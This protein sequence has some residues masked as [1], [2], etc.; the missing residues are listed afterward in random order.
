MSDYSAYGDIKLGDKT[1]SARVEKTLEQLSSNPTTS[2]SS[3]CN[4]PHQAKAVYR[5]LSNDKFTADAVLEVSQK[6]TMR[7]IAESGELV[8]LMPQDTTSLNY[9]GL[10][11]TEGLGTICDNKNALGILLHSSIAVSENGQ[12]FG[13]LSAKAWVRPPEEFGKK[14][15][16]KQLPIEE[17][18][19]YKW[20]ET[21]DQVH[22]PEEL[23]HVHFIHVCD[24]EGDLYELFAKA[25]LEGATYLCRRVQNRTVIN[26]NEEELA[27]TKYLDALPVVGEIEVDVPR[28]S[29]TKREARTARLEIKC[30]TVL[31]KKPANL[32]TSEKI[33]I[34]VEVSLVSAQEIGLADD[35]DAISW[36][37]ITNESVE[38]FEDAV[39]CVKRYMQRWKIEVFHH[40]LKSGC[41]IE[42]AQESTAEKLIKLISLYSVIALQI[43]ILTHLARTNPDASC[44]TFFEADEWK[45]LYKV[46]KKTKSVPGNPPSIREAVFM[47]AKL[48]GF[49]GRKSDGFPGV[50]TIWR[51]LIKFHNIIDASTYLI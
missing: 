44:E 40:V 2:I 24:R 49:L 10:K 5:L 47:I 9:S 13:L 29:H 16:R 38:T 37:L 33:P 48:G 21:L 50:V 12:P 30:G 43:M 17:K 23:K 26:T 39:T 22:I 32:K 28:A 34:S 11:N 15:K 51:G 14:E 19:S 20:L 42:K 35:K 31:I 36:Q 27:I 3:A 45:I 41:T 7:R 4:D 6:E 18:E 1:L 25:Y 8:V 46:A